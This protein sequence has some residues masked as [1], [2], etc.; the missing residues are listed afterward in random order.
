MDLNVVQEL[1]LYSNISPHIRCSVQQLLSSVSPAPADAPRET[2][3]PRSAAAQ[4][5]RSQFGAAGALLCGLPPLWK[6][7]VAASLQWV[8]EKQWKKIF[9]TQT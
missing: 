1:T 8:G 4:Q 5:P 9:T 2:P 7:C 6:S 3:L